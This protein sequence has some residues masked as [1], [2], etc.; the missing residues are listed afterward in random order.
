MKTNTQCNSN[1]GLKFETLIYIKKNY[2]K[3]IYSQI[4]KQA[5]INCW[6]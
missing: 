1:Y 6:L 2:D 3:Y 5:I 4:Y